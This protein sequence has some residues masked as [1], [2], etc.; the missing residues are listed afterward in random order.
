MNLPKATEKCGTPE[1]DT[2]ASQLDYVVCSFKWL[3]IEELELLD[4]VDANVK[5]ILKRYLYSFWDRRLPSS[6]FSLI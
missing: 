5:V 6:M 4:V 1:T 3:K 2:F